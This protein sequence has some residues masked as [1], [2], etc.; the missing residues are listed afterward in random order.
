MPGL[1]GLALTKEET[2]EILSL[3]ATSAARVDAVA[4][5]PGWVVVGSFPIPTTADIR[6]D[7]LGSVSDPSLTMSIRLYCTTP[8]SVGMVSGSQVALASL[9]D[10]QVFSSAF[11]V[12]G[13]R[14][15]QVQSQVVGNAGASYFGN[16]RRVAPAGI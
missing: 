12:V 6:L 7:V 9:V 8:G 14:S 16:L 10:V 11:T 4:T 13:N 2:I 1:S 15:Y 3:Y 5:A